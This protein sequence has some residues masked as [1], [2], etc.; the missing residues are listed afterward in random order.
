MSLILNLNQNKNVVKDSFNY[1]T[2]DLSLVMT[3]WE[4]V[5]LKYLMFFWHNCVVVCEYTLKEHNP[6]HIFHIKEN[7]AVSF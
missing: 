3:N 2:C 6:I 4:Q 1:G 7:M 5:D